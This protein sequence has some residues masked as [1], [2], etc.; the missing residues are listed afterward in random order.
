MVC[1]NW[2]VKWHSGQIYIPVVVLVSME[3]DTSF[4]LFLSSGLGSGAK[5]FM[6]NAPCKHEQKFVS[7]HVPAVLMRYGYLPKS[8]RRGGQLPHW[9][10]LVIE[11]TSDRIP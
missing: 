7:L 5:A 10:H 1:E 3:L 6:F 2:K 9:R 8:Y 4:F 11:V